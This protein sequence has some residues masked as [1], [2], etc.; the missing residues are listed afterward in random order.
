MF[1][2]KQKLLLFLVLLV[3]LHLVRGQTARVQVIHNSADAAAAVVDVYLNDNL[4][5][6]DFAF[7]TATEFIDAPAGSPIS[8]D[9]A[10][11]TSSS[12]GESIYNLTTTLDQTKTYVLVASGIVSGSGYAPAKPFA[13]DVFDMGQEA[14]GTPGNTDVLVYHGSTDAPT[15]DVYEATGPAL[16]V[17]DLVY[18][19]FSPAYLALPTA[20][21]YL[22]V[23]DETGATSLLAYNAPLATL[24]LDD[25]AA[26][27]VASGFL[28]PSV[29]SDGPGFGLYVALPA[30]GDL[31]P[32]PESTARVQVIHNSADAAA[33]AVDVY[34]N[35]GILIDDFAFR[36]ASAFID[37]PA[38]VEVSIDVA[39]GTSSSS[40][41]SIY[42][43]TTTL[44]PAKTYVLVASGIVSGSGYTPVTPFAIDVF[45]MG[46]EAA[47]TPGN[48]DVLVYHG[49]TDAPTVDVYEKSGPTELI[50]NLSYSQFNGYLAL[51]TADYVLELREETGTTEIVSYDAPL[52]TLGLDDQAI[53]VVASGFLVPDNNSSGPEFGLYVALTTG[54]D[55]VALPVHSPTNVLPSVGINGILVYPNPVKDQMNLLLDMDGLVK[56][57]VITSSGKVAY[58]GAAE[59]INGTAILDMKALSP[60]VYILKIVDDG[61][62]ITRSFIKK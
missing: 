47:G 9:V 13:I 57:K 61:K 29:N 54:G 37:A 43:L 20:D 26:V 25:A 62:V 3:S 48:T 52:S 22:Q 7:R 1:A 53:V 16:L 15:V 10:P 45:D 33:S 18:S 39:P 2:M 49:S 27:V 38:N 12:S 40:G 6:D 23:R 42:N 56:Y 30:G 14:A 36:T 41:E 31:V 58:A 17:D 46:Q 11:G 19:A 60:G 32:L 44:D 51:P 5:I 8:I 35:D 28:D 34:L 4:L 21:Y 55:L 59:V 24:G 50:D